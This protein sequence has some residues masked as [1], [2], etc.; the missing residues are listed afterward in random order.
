VCHS[1]EA[2][3]DSSSE[4]WKRGYGGAVGGVWPS[5]RLAGAW[6]QAFCFVLMRLVGSRREDIFAFYLVY[7]EM[8]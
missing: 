7:K 1:C 4:K 8:L 3:G 2:G 6:S 5:Q